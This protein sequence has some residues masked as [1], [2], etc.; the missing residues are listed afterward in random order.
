LYLK[1]ENVLFELIDAVLRPDF[2]HNSK[3]NVKFINE[4]AIDASGLTR[5]ALRTPLMH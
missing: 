5:E 1:R 3:L 4:E 2:N